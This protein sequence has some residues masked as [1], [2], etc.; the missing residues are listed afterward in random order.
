GAS[1]AIYC[2]LM[3]ACNSGVVPMHKVN[4]DAKS[5]Y[6]MIQNYKVLQ[7]VF[8]KLRIAKHIDVNKLI[9]GRPLDNLEFMQWLKRYCDSTT[10]RNLIL[11]IPYNAAE[12]REMCKGGKEMNRKTALAYNSQTTGLMKT[13]VNSLCSRRVDSNEGLNGYSKST[14]RNTLPPSLSQAA[15]QI[16]ALFEQVAELKVA[17]DNL[18]KERDFYFRKLGDIENICQRPELLQ[19]P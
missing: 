11:R 13:P 3:D 7:E 12:R 8:N 5:E 4:F 2:Q 9:K 14:P 16:R 10:A 19:I 15:L 17:V 1:G 18:E 6:E